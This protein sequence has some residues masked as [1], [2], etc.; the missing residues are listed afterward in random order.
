MGVM[1]IKPSCSRYIAYITYIAFIT[2]IAYI[3]GKRHGLKSN[4]SDP[5][6]LASLP[7]SGRLAN[8][9]NNNNNNTGTL[10]A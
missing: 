1:I 2:Y 4:M 3:T 5:C 8:N 7:L 6:L 10:Y 9:N